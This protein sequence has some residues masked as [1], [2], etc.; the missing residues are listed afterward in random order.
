MTAQIRRHMWAVVAAS[1]VATATPAR[2]KKPTSPLIYA[3]IVGNNDG[4]GMLPQ[5]QYADD[6]ALRFYR[7]ATLLTPPRN[8]ALLTELD[9]ETWR[10]IQL[11]GAQ[12]PPFLPPTRHRLLEV[13]RLFKKQIATAR[14]AD[15]DR[16]VHLYFFFSGHGERGY[17]FLKR[18]GGPLADAAFTG[19]DLQRTFSDSPATLNW[20]FIDA[21]KSQSLF[22]PK[23]EGDDDELGPDFSGLIDKLETT[24]KDAPVGVLTATVSD[25]PAG[26]ARDIHGG[27][28]SHVLTSG[29]RG[30]ADADSDGIIQYKE[31]A[32]FVTF[33]T[34]RMGGQQ[35]WF[36][37]PQGK[38]SEPLI[39][40]SDRPNLLW[41]PP[42][43]AGHFALFDEHGRQL[44]VELHKTAEQ[45]S[46][47]IL[48]PG[49]YKVVWIKDKERG[50]MATV[51]VGAGTTRVMMADFTDEVT[52]GP[53]LRPR[54]DEP[55]AD[56]TAMARFDPAQSGFDQ[57]FSHRIVDAVITGY[58]SGRFESGGGRA[59]AAVTAS[60]DRPRTRPHRLSL[61]YG[62]YAPPV[63]PFSPGQG[64]SLAYQHRFDLPISAG[65]RGLFT[66]SDHDAHGV[67]DAFSMQRLMLQAEAA[68]RAPRLWRLD[69][70]A[71]L[72]VGWQTVIITRQTLVRDGEK[73]RMATTINGD[74]AGFRAGATL[75][76]Q[77]DIGAGIWA[78]VRGAYGVELVHETDDSGESV[79]R[80]FWRPQ[81]MAE[82][83]YGF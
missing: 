23:G 62:F 8:V 12:P 30:A 70:L 15:P 57:P 76:V 68:Y 40:L 25:Q 69:L 46:R 55:G 82:I 7:L 49:R 73:D 31:L 45:H 53:D 20:L 67:R 5:L 17:F 44:L 66:F 77:A 2:A 58:S 13:I 42:G 56:D 48:A 18:K 11:S 3:V 61:G 47:L 19:T 28:F 51:T 33:H 22:A 36:R 14:K 1:L 75:A 37:P 6:D 65:I 27:Y 21:C 50:V 24:V 71:G 41:M 43:A 52:L 35:P 54:G 16:P 29:L 72:Y 34:R 38:L 9:V 80:T 63:E 32:A 10:R 79:A 39:V 26:E 60:P 64:V 59:D 4:L 83:G 74:P 81:V 78:G